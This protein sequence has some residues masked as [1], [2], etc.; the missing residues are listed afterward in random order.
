MARVYH[1]HCARD[2]KMVN[3]PP[4]F[5]KGFKRKDNKDMRKK[6]IAGNWKMNVKPSETAALVKG[7]ADAT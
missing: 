7:I 5:P 3:Y 2:G 6:I 1:N 4:F